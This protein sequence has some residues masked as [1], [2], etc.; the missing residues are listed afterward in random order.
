MAAILFISLFVLMFLG[1]PIAF[2]ILT[3]C[4]TLLATTDF[5]P[6]ILVAQRLMAGLDSFPL[7]AGPLFIVSGYLMS[8]SSM[9][10]RLVDWVG[11]LFGNTPGSMGTVT[12]VA[13]AI[14]AAL[15]GSGPATV[16]AI[17][18]LMLPAMIEQGYSR[19][20]ASG[21]LASAGALGP[22]IP[23]STAMIVYGAAMSLSI[24]DMFI[25]SVI[26]GIFIALSLVVVNSIMAS[27]KH[28]V[29]KKE[30]V[31]FKEVVRLTWR[32]LPV[33]FLPV[34]ILGGIYS[35]VFTPTEAGCVAVV[36]STI[37]GFM[38]KELTIKGFFNVLQESLETSA[39]VMF[40][41]A[42]AN[43][44]GFILSTANIPSDFSNWV[45]QFIHT[46][47][48]YMII[49]LLIL[50][51]VGCLMETIASIVI[52]APILVPV[53][54]T[55]GVDPLHLG[56]I[57][58]IT[59]VAGFVTPPFGVNI[60]TAVSVTGESYSGVVKGLMP[61]LLVMILC[62]VIMAFCPWFTTWLPSM[63]NG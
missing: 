34:I 14:F 54:L 62:V 19:S 7:L 55:L 29:V 1:V 4:I 42:V 38:F 53:G 5:K 45:V 31:P 17:G 46:P 24:P 18:G 61:Y 35:G 12:I 52:L 63:M 6:M 33:L 20:S 57:F 40:I 2:S 30:K 49:L 41:L 8:Y 23:P 13:C 21:L 36:Y 25:G 3:S 48:Q 51:V 22:I 60:F 50:L 32:A 9:S 47:T 28:I 59:L 56:C 11:C 10:R 27:R 26:P 43:L 37:V 58:C 15:T 44:F 39:V 16:A